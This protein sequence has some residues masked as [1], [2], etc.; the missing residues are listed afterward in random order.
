MGSAHPHRKEFLSRWL[1]TPGPGVRAAIRTAWNRRVL[2]A[3]ERCR[4]HGREPARPARTGG[5]QVFGRG[6]QVWRRLM[7]STGAYGD[8]EKAG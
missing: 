4:A 8:R 7:R 5:A 1:I 3:K 6:T 2:I